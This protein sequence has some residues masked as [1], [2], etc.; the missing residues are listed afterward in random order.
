[1]TRKQPTHEKRIPSLTTESCLGGLDHVAPHSLP[2]A[3]D[4]TLQVKILDSQPKQF[5]GPHASFG[6]QPV[7]CFM[8]ILGRLNDSLYLF[9]REKEAPLMGDLREDEPIERVV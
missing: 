7:E 4:A 2:N 1:M 9:D 6:R 8:R 3:D 5:S